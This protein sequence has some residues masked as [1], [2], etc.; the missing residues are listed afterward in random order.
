MIITIGVRA[1][2]C[3]VAYG[4]DGRGD[5]VGDYYSDGNVLLGC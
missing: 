2:D 3:V 1:G 4:G 5:V